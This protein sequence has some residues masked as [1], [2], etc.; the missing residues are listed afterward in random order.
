MI[1]AWFMHVLSLITVPAR[2]NADAGF[3]AL[4]R[5]CLIVD[6]TKVDLIRSPA[7][8]G[9]ELSQSAPP[10]HNNET[11]GAAADA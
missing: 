9:S 3:V 5:D 10:D 8:V 11:R 1:K 2:R 6:K 4:S 7:T